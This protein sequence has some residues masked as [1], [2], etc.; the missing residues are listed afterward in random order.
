MCKSSMSALAGD[1]KMPSRVC[2]MQPWLFSSRS[3]DKRPFSFPSLPA[4]NKAISESSGSTERISSLRSPTNLFWDPLGTGHFWPWVYSIH[5]LNSMFWIEDCSR[6]F[7]GWTEHS[8]GSSST[9]DGNPPLCHHDDH[10]L[11][12]HESE[13]WTRWDRAM[14]FLGRKSG[15]FELSLE[16]PWYWRHV[17]VDDQCTSLITFIF[18]VGRLLGAF[19]MYVSLRFSGSWWPGVWG[20]WQWLLKGQQRRG[21]TTSRG[22][23][24]RR[25]SH[26]SH[27]PWQVWLVDLC[28][29]LY[30]L[31]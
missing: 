30:H 12:L 18:C 6:W 23:C 4:P 11:G 25:R 20:S 22:R 10:L 9:L 14:T 13:S 26:L 19:E 21:K 2:M 3:L 5:L 15:E 24:R 27:K 31:F 28:R 16:G 1:V 8:F 17:D 7:L 29:G